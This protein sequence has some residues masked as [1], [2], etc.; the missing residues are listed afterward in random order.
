MGQS[1]GPLNLFSSL[2]IFVYKDL[3]SLFLNSEELAKGCGEVSLVSSSTKEETL[4]TSNT[5]LQCLV[6]TQEAGPSP[7]DIE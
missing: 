7:K 4:S 5:G 1:T 6:L 2:G 3:S